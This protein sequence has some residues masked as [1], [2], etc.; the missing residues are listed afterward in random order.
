MTVIALIVNKPPTNSLYIDGT[1]TYRPNASKY[2]N[3]DFKL[4]NSGNNKDVDP[5]GEG[6]LV[7]MSGK[8]TYR[9]DH[10]PNPM[11]VCL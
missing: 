5:F 10:G 4:F 1:A 6:D 8:F 11:F 2:K 9:K 7:M 3:F